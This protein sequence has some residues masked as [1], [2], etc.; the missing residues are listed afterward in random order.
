VLE[1]YE[2]TKE[3]DR[4]GKMTFRRKRRDGDRDM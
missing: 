3:E 4:V 1:N 2:W